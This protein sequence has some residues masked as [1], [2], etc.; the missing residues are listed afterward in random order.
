[1]IKYLY[2]KFYNI[3]EMF[4]MGRGISAGIFLEF[5]VASRKVNDFSD[6]FLACYELECGEENLYKINESFF[7]ENYKGLLEEFNYF[8]EIEEVGCHH[9][10]EKELTIDDVPDFKTMEEFCS[11]WNKSKRKGGMPLNCKSDFDTATG[12]PRLTWLFYEGTYKANLEDYYSLYHFEKA[13]Q[14]AIKN[15]LGKLVKLGLYG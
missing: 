6:D 13:V 9:D 4:F 8:F 3:E 12:I 7:L 15:P 5:E 14:D 11:F 10:D 2:I 1:M